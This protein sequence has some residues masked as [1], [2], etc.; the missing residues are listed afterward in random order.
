MLILGHGGSFTSKFVKESL[1]KLV[2]EHIAAVSSQKSGSEDLASI[3]DLLVRSFIAAD[4]SLAAETRMAV[5]SKVK[6]SR[7]GG[8]QQ[9]ESS[10]G[11]KVLRDFVTIDNSGSTACTCK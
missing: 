9:Q 2:S 11:E 5:K 10:V 4:E 8:Q 7:R 1:S 6:V 3:N